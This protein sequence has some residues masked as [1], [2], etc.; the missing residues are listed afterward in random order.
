MAEPIL[1]EEK[2]N[3]ETFR[4]CLSEPVLKALAMPA[5][6]PRKKRVKRRKGKEIVSR[7]TATVE[8]TEQEMPINS[9]DAEELGEFIEL[10]HL[11]QPPP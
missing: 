9:T 1:E 4:E 11:P 6:A 8:P 2:S 5:E 7:T 3:Y 10:P